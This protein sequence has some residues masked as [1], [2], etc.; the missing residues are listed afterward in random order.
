MNLR[1]VTCRFCGHNT[2]MFSPICGKCHQRKSFA[3]RLPIMALPPLV[4]VIV[5]VGVATAGLLIRNWMMP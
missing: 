4:T 2:R 5:L 1:G 3:Q